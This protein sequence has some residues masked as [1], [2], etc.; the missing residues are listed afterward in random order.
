V[1]AAV[2]TRYGPPDVVEVRDVPKPE[3]GAGEVLVRVRATTVSR[4]DCGALRAYPFFTRFFT[5]LTRPKR[6]ILG[7]DFAGEIE[8]VGAGVT[9]FQPGERVFGLTPGGYGGHAQ[10]LVMPEQGAIA[11]M[12]AGVPFD[13]A[14]VCEGALYADTDLRALGLGSGNTIL[15]YGGSGAIGSAAVQ[16]AKAYGADVT[17]VVATRHLEL[18]TSLGADHAI[19][20]TAQDFTTIGE[21]FDFVFDAVG[22]VSYLRARRLLAPGGRFTATD[23]GPH[24]QNLLIILWCALTRSKKLVFPIPKS[25]KA[26]VEWLAARIEAGQFRAVIDRKYPLEDIV[27]AYRYVE[28]RQKTGIVVIDVA[29]E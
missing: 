28:T 5:G 8:A 23:F 18:V 6:T 7:M 15:I 22:T 24:N 11:T 14:V 4:T 12:P 21:T 2:N 29:P 13:E 19:D 25:T 10:Y 9:L 1:K 26:F 17:A 16:L 3:P 27:E 20:S